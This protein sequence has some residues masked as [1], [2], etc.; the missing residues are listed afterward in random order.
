MLVCK[1]WFNTSLNFSDCVAA[2]CGWGVK[3]STT[4]PPPTN[5][6]PRF[7]KKQLIF[8]LYYDIGYICMCILGYENMYVCV[9]VVFHFKAVYNFEFIFKLALQ[10]SFYTHT[11]AASSSAWHVCSWAAAYAFAV[12][13][14]CLSTAR[15]RLSCGALVCAATKQII[16]SWVFIK[17]K[18]A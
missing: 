8:Q 11:P 12:A 4:S 6:L 15:L 2:A 7:L 18:Y 16:Y 1:L 17:R 10:S 5:Y 14:V 9:S 13:C 3:S